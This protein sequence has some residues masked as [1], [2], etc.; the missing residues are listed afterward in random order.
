MENYRLVMVGK[1]KKLDRF[2]KEVIT[3]DEREEALIIAT[4]DKSK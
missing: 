1:F 2:D 4:T 3:A